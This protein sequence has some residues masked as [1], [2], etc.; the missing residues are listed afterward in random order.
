MAMLAQLVASIILVIA[1]VLNGWAGTRHGVPFPVLARSAFGNAGAHVC[2]LSRGAV[3]IMWLS[4]QIW[5]ATL[6]V[7]VALQRCFGVDSMGHQGVAKGLLFS[8]FLLIHAVLVYLG[9]ARFKGL[10][11]FTLPALSLGLLGVMIWASTI[12]DFGEA[13]HEIHA[14]PQ[15]FQGSPVL[16][17]LTAVNSSI[18]TWSTLVLNVCDLSRFSP[19]QSDQALGQALG[20]PLPFLITG[21]AGMWMAGATKNAFGAASWQIPELFAFWSP[22]VSLLASVVLAISIIVVNVLANILSPI[23]DLMNLA[24]QSFSFRICG[25]VTLALSAAVCPWWLFSSQNRFVLTFLSGYGMVTGALAGVLL[26]D[27]WIL[28]RQHLDMKELY[29]GNANINWCALFA[30]LLGIAPG[31]P[32]FVS[33]L[34]VKHGFTIPFWEHL[35]HGGSWLIALA[36]SGSAHVLLHWLHSCMTGIAFRQESDK[37]KL[38]TP[39]SSA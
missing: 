26:S 4:F 9:P 1:L 34:V 8:A 38:D 5:Q 15:T 12:A 17:F 32:G 37:Q 39:E 22:A 11:K 21:F 24:P 25:Y 20:L 27:Y 29:S 28:R 16:A 18:A 2:T 35:Y 30:T 19:K 6:G 36:I 14:E 7:F 10:V 13:M 33:T 3:A 23:N 31:M